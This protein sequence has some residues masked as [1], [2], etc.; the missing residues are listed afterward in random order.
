MV[1]EAILVSNHE[2]ISVD[3]EGE[4]EVDARQYVRVG[5]VSFRVRKQITRRF[6]I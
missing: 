2:T 5:V 3:E 6:Q 1:I 4:I